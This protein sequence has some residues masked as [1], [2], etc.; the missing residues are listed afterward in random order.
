MM[1]QR[2][3]VMV[4][5]LLAFCFASVVGYSNY[6]AKADTSAETLNNQLDDAN[7]KLKDAQAELAAENSKLYKNKTQMSSTQALIKQ[8]E[9]DIARREAELKNLNDRAELNKSMLAEYIRQVYYTD[10][11]D[12][13][14]RLTIENGKLNNIVENFDSIVVIKGKIIDALQI[15]KD[16]KVMNE[17][18]KLALADQQQ[19]KQRVLQT[20][21]VEQAD[22]VDNIQEAQ[23]TVAELNE[24]IA[25]LKSALSSFLGKSYSTKDI[26]DAVKF[27]SNATGIRKEFLQAELIVET[28][29]G[30]FTGGCRYND[31]KNLR[32]RTTDKN[33]FL[34]IAAELEKAYGGNYKNKKLSCT[35]KRN[36]VFF[37]YGG[38]MGVAQF[39]PTTWVGYKS[40]ISAKTG[41]SP[42]DPWD[43]ADGITG[44]AIKLA[45]GGATSKN[46]EFGASM[47][48]YCGST[49]PSPASR[50][51]S[52]RNY[53]S[54]VQKYS[55][56]PESHM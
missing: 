14:V 9:T 15:I 16:A 44:M 52:C 37:G 56:D 54:L 23:A 12:P 34:K 24:K 31:T 18:T 40:K 5:L 19:N 48:Y 41:S 26:D 7:K 27:A 38:A 39:M 10:Q 42:A 43:L 3:T 46:G 55:K 30:T 47:L 1:I 13:I 50:K 2:K 28:G 45:T 11:E 25:E 4:L 21:K 53:A 17:K 20:Q 49:N 32:M 8:I 33:E 22:I 35:P 51:T 36:G 6:S 29:Y